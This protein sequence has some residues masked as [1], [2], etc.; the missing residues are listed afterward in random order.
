M[1]PTSKPKTRHSNHLHQNWTHLPNVFY[2]ISKENQPMCDICLN[3]RTVKHIIEECTKYA[4]TLMDL[5]MTFNKEDS[6]K[7]EHTMKIINFLT[8][9]NIIN[10]L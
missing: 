7:E 10:K 5:N 4:S 3:A 2:L 8:I 1:A 9:I 6:R